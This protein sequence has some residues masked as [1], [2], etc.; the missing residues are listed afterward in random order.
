MGGAAAVVWRG[1]RVDPRT[2]DMLDEVARLTPELPV[3]SPSQG[4]Y[5]TGVDASANTHAGGG[6]VDIRASNLTAGQTIQTVRVMRRVGF[7]A[8]RR[9]PSEGNWAEHVH[10][11]AVGCPDLSPAA[12]RQVEAL[13]AGRNG[14]RNEMPDRHA[15]L[16]L[17]V[18]TWEAYRSGDDDMLGLKQGDQGERV[19]VLQA[20]LQYAGF[21]PVGGADGDYGPKTAESVVEMRRSVGSTQVDTDKGRVINAWA[22]AQLHLCIAKAN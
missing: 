4:S 20:M 5:T 8:W 6:A 7:A 18:T 14:L 10:A 13:R 22:L 11:I 19:R 16:G 1:V 15:D 3:L 9:L 2:R 21:K 17:P 12:A